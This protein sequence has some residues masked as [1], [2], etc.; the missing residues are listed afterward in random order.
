MNSVLSTC[1][2]SSPTS[3]TYSALQPQTT[4]SPQKAFPSTAV[5]KPRSAWNAS[6]A[7]AAFWGIAPPSPSCRAS[8]ALCA[9]FLSAASAGP[10]W[11]KGQWRHTNG[12][13]Q[14]ASYPAPDKPQGFHC[15][16]CLPYA[17]PGILPTF[18]F[19]NNFFHLIFFKWHEY[20]QATELR[21]RNGS[22]PKLSQ[23]QEGRTGIL[24]LLWEN[25]GMAR[26]KGTQISVASWLFLE[27]DN[28]S[29]F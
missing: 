22:I 3:D 5:H 16:C 4:Y 1:T 26:A 19:I 27:R 17:E 15:F 13:Q 28:K 2:T 11:N 23:Q 21:K 7:P 24:S 25:A 18:L 20:Q 12:G 14:G 9:H 29:E 10:F 8:M 6:L